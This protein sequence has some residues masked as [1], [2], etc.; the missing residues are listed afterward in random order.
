MP[1]ANLLE[2]RADGPKDAHDLLQPIKSQF[3]GIKPFH[4]GYTVLGGVKI[5]PIQK[6]AAV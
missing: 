5:R 6:K 2:K 1:D 4:Q 3:C